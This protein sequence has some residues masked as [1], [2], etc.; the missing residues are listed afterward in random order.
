MMK[1]YRMKTELDKYVTFLYSIEGDNSCE[2]FREMICRGIPLCNKFDS[3]ELERPIEEQKEA[4]KIADCSKLW[5][6]TGT[7]VFSEK[8]KDCLE[9][10]IRGCVEFIPAVFENTTYYIINILSIA[11]AI[12]YEKAEFQRL[13]T[14]LVVGLEKYSFHE[15]RLKGLNIFVT[16]LNGYIQSTEVF[17]TSEFKKV[18][19]KNKLLGFKFIEVWNSQMQKN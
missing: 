12:D 15:E 14:G 17:V 13:S 4:K 3:I 6:K 16:T 1:I 19:E 9:E 10:L 18:V 2:E 8:A 5:N 7:Y 11:D